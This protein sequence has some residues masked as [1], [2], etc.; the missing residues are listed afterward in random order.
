[1]SDHACNFILE[2]EFESPVAT[3]LPNRNSST[4]ET[5]S[6]PTTLSYDGSQEIDDSYSDKKVDNIHT[7]CDGKY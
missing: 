2:K 1:M 5:Q 4:T 6:L 7:T 3:D